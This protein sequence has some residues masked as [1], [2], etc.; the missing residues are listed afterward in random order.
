MVSL[1]NHERAASGGELYA[2]KAMNTAWPAPD[3]PESIALRQ[4][5]GE[6]ISPVRGELVESRDGNDHPFSQFTEVESS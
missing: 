4:A 2:G 6:R 5:Q 3:C 1:S